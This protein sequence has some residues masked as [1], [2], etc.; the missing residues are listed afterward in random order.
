MLSQSAE[1]ADI[2]D[3]PLRLNGS[4]TGMGETLNIIKDKDPL[5]NISFTFELDSKDNIRKVL[6]ATK[7][8]IV[9]NHE[10]IIRYMPHLIMT[11]GTKSAELSRHLEKIEQFVPHAADHSKSIEFRK[12]YLKLIKAYRTAI[13]KD[14]RQKTKEIDLGQR[15]S[16]RL[17][18]M[19]S[20]QKIADCVDVFLGTPLSRLIPAKIKY[21]FYFNKRKELL[22]VCEY[23]QHNKLGGMIFSFKK[24]G[25]N[26][27]ISSDIIEASILKRSR[28]EIIKPI[29]LDSMQ[30]AGSV[31]SA[32]N[33]YSSFHSLK[34]SSSPLAATLGFFLNATSKHLLQSLGM[35]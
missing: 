16:Y 32:S 21:S 33:G 26:F 11:T 19:F 13:P 23:T 2:S 14:K 35:L 8:T 24:E 9:Q 17:P 28:S 10:M 25:N 4:K 34:G 12:H 3:S 27:Q 1:S 20:I 29:T 5:K 15:I 22:S 31:S 6:S 7:Q 30:I 18:S